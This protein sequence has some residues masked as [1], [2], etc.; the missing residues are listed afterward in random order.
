MEIRVQIERARHDAEHLVQPGGSSTRYRVSFGGEEIGVWRDPESSAARYLLDKGLASREDTLQTYHGDDKRLRG[1]VGW[2]AD[3][4]VR[5]T[6]SEGPV[7]IKWK[8]FPA[9]T[10]LPRTA[11]KRRGA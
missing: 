11:K 6:S 9:E 3:R 10:S 4:L 8:P 1:R 5:E 2:L 7:H